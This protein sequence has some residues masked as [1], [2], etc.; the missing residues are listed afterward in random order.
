VEP[1]KTKQTHEQTKNRS[2]LINTANKLVI[3]RGEEGRGMGKIG[4][5]D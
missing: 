3:A 1:T 2:I 5:G 4:K